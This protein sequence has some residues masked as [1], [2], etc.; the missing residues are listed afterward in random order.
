[1][2]LLEARI[3]DMDLA[4]NT[5]VNYQSAWKSFETWCA[6]AALPALP[7]ST[8]TVCD[9]V[10][11]CLTVGYRLPTVTVRIAAIGYFHRRE[12]LA[13]PINPEVREYTWQAQRLLRHKSKGKNAITIEIL[14]RICSRLAGAG[15]YPVAIRN[16]TMI[17]L[18]FAAGFRRSELSGLLV[19]DL[20]F[21]PEGVVVALN[22]SKTDQEG[23]GRNVP[24]ERGSK[25]GLCP[26]AALERWLQVR[27]RGEGPL[28]VQFDSRCRMTEKGVSASG[29][30]LNY[31]LKGILSK[32]GE[33]PRNYG[34]HSLRAGMITEAVRNGAS[35]FAIM[36]RTGHRSSE[37]LRS[38][39]RP[40]NL[41]EMNPLKGVL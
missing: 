23:K 28:F 40:A 7:A 8:K 18:C 36:Q 17:L 9:F 3:R 34:A 19:R 25:P 41:F 39:I 32:I 33:N 27:G 20:T 30:L 31:M 38:Y 5:R 1:M 35:E 10:T 37:V 11:W 21:C 22:Y 6:V 24:I 29:C 13:N 2:R 15:E 14:Q 16:W 4:T 12:G 26:V